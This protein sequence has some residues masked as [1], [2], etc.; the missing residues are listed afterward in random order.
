MKLVVT[1]LYSVA[2]LAMVED[3][4]SSLPDKR[5]MV[6]AGHSSKQAGRT[7]LTG[8]SRRVTN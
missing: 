6:R 5:D 8:T 7:Q 4:R 1:G 2:R 3:H